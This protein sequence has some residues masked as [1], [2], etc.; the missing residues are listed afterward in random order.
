MEFRFWQAGGGYD[1]NVGDE[2]TLRTMI[3]YIHQN[4]VRRGLVDRPED[5]IWSSARWY[6]GLDPVVL[7]MDGT[8]PMVYEL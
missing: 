2:S 4:P 7:E 3:D 1:R 5:W 8:L 6:A